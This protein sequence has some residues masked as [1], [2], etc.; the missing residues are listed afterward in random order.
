MPLKESSVRSYLGMKAGD[1]QIPLLK[2]ET[3][4]DEL[5]ASTQ[6]ILSGGAGSSG[7]GE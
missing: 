5:E 4:S 1:C 3:L 2:G 7:G 6:T